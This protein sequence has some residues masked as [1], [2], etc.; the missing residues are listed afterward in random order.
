MPDAK[1]RGQHRLFPQPPRLRPDRPSYAGYPRP[2][3]PSLVCGMFHQLFCVCGRGCLRR[4][5]RRSRRLASYIVHAQF[6]L[7]RLHYDRDAGIVTYEARTS[8]RS[9]LPSRAAECFSPL[10]VLAALTA[11]IPEK[12]LQVVLMAST[13]AS[14][15][16][17]RWPSQNGTG[18]QRQWCAQP[19]TAE[20]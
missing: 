19:P 18:L 1:Q 20:G 12:G 10:N 6:S 9:N 16:L 4:R 14:D 7:A 5:Q 8:P 3:S 13:E 11:H 17:R 2:F 15:A